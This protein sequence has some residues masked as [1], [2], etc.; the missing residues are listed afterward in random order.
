MRIP[1]HAVSSLPD[2]KAPA[3]TFLHGLK[4]P[5]SSTALR[6]LR[7]QKRPTGGARRARP[8]KSKGSKSG[9]NRRGNKSAKGKFTARVH[10]RRGRKTRTR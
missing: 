8:A 9:G 3:W 10:K 7:R 6:A 1:E 5:L 4:S 2:R